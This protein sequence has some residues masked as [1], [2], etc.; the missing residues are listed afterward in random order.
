MPFNP[1]GFG[2]DI[3]PI[4]VSY[5]R[6][7]IRPVGTTRKIAMQSRTFRSGRPDGPQGVPHDQ[8]SRERWT[9]RHISNVEKHMGI[10]RRMGDLHGPLTAEG[11]YY[12]WK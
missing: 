5:R 2:D 7:R 12:T 4:G 1:G 6:S 9:E 11:R 8:P 10:R 3:K